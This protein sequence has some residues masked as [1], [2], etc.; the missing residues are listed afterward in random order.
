MINNDPPIIIRNQTSTIQRENQQ[1]NIFSPKILSNNQTKENVQFDDRM[2]L[3]SMESG[4]EE[5]KNKN[6]PTEIKN[7]QSIQSSNQSTN[8]NSI[9]KKK[10]ETSLMHLISKNLENSVNKSKLKPKEELKKVEI[11]YLLI[12]GMFSIL[13]LI[14]SFI[15]YQ[16]MGPSHNY[17][18]YLTNKKENKTNIEMNSTISDSNFNEIKVSNYLTTY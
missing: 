7:K 5:P 3:P 4:N 11:N 13:M 12:F 10:N 15:F 6:I 18:L 1:K 2:P 9:S 16:F 17:D 14:Y 8:K